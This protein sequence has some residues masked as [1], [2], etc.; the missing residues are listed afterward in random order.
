MSL[1]KR[2][3][4]LISKV[5]QGSNAFVWPPPPHHLSSLNNVNGGREE[6]CRWGPTRRVA[7][8]APSDSTMVIRLARAGWAGRRLNMKTILTSSQGN[9]GIMDKKRPGLQRRTTQHNTAHKPHASRLDCHVV[10]LPP[11]PGG[12]RGGGDGI[13]EKERNLMKRPLL[14]P[15][16][17][18]L[19]PSPPHC[20]SLPCSLRRPKSVF[21]QPLPIRCHGNPG[22][23]T[24]R[25]WRRLRKA[26]IIIARRPLGNGSGVIN[27][28]LVDSV[29][30]SDRNH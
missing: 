6:R 26:W 10:F 27:E 28:R 7:R 29:F 22:P 21:A 4:E 8:S 25:R 11:A 1:W 3:K 18:D 15:A 13:W 23:A 14:T 30:I 20:F 19:P 24:S 2:W 9:Y 16:Q 5:C 12:G 17:Q